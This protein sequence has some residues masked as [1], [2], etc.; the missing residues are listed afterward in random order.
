MC[1]VHEAHWFLVVPAVEVFVALRRRHC[2]SWSFCWRSVVGCSIVSP[3]MALDPRRYSAARH[4]HRV[5]VSRLAYA[6]VM[7][8]SC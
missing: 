5:R 7:E 2:V 4:I 3:G 6:V 8:T 1:A